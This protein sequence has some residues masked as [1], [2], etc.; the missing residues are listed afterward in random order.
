MK[1][2]QEEIQRS[3]KLMGLSEGLNLQ[4]KK[5]QDKYFD[6]NTHEEFPYSEIDKHPKWYKLEFDN[7]GHFIYRETNKGFWKRW[8]YDQ[9]GNIIC[10]RTKNG[11]WEKY[12]YDNRG[13]TTYYE[14][15]DGIWY[16]WEFDQRG[17]IIYCETSYGSWIKREY[18]ADGNQIYMENSDGDIVDNRNGQLS[19]G[20]NLPPIT[21]VGFTKNIINHMDLRVENPDKNDPNYIGY[22][23]KDN[24]LVMDENISGKFEKGWFSIS[25]EKIYTPI[26]R[27]FKL[28]SYDTV[29]PIIKQA[30]EELL[31]KKIEFVHNVGESGKGSIIWHRRKY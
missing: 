29:A 9:H 28:D 15:S 1:N 11:K 24:N 31:N 10:Y 8:E 16:K 3:K 20:L 2:L 7:M 5:Y 22:Y 19:E 12:E 30:L 4:K 13:N 21:P 25:Y 27:K 14:N 18:D 26:A 6:N 17:K 23:D